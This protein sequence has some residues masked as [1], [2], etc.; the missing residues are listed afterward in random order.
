MQ[1]AD[2]YGLFICTWPQI[3]TDWCLADGLDLLQISHMLHFIPNE[4]EENVQYFDRKMGSL[5]FRW[6]CGI[7]SYNGW[8]RDTV[9]FFLISLHIQKAN[10]KKTTCSQNVTATGASSDWNGKEWPSPHWQTVGFPGSFKIVS[11]SFCSLPS[12]PFPPSPF[13]CVYI[14]FCSRHKGFETVNKNKCNYPLPSAPWQLRAQAAHKTNG[15][16]YRWAS[17]NIVLLRVSL[18]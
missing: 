10:R 14:L 3:I 9:N 5:Y 12:I 1:L 17:H 16:Y 13:L 11:L 6:N 4:L 18:E 2:N 7:G 8:W 15:T